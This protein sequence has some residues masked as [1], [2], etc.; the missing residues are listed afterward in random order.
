MDRQYYNLVFI[1][2]ENSDKIYLFQAPL[3]IRLKADEKVFVDTIQGECIGTCVSNSFIVGEY[4]TDC[5]VVATGAYK[6]LKDVI[7]WAEKQ[8]GYRCIDFGLVDI[9][10]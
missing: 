8:E 3:T 6:P 5:I 1:K 4:E 7:G 9:P 10:F 2:H